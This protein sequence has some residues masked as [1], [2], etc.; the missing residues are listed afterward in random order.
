M[1]V[2]YKRTITA[3]RYHADP[4]CNCFRCLECDLTSFKTEAEASGY[5]P[6]STIHAPTLDAV[7]G[8]DSYTRAVEHIIN[9]T[10]G[11]QDH[12]ITKRDSEGKNYWEQHELYVKLWVYAVMGLPDRMSKHALGKY[13][14]SVEV[15]EIIEAHYRLGG[16][17]AVKTMLLT[18]WAKRRN[19]VD[20]P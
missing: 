3:H 17:P 13:K 5:K 19:R 10:P 18:R 6:I 7:L 16:V 9:G 15:Q 2:S 1:L 4:A 12:A 14:H 8:N 11:W 20:V